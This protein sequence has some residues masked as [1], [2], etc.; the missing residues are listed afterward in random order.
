MFDIEKKYWIVDIAA[1]AEC[2]SDD[3]FE[4][5]QGLI[6]KVDILSNDGGQYSVEK[7]E[8]AK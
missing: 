6:K 4:T 3:E 2:L 1:G 7:L 5:L 8:G